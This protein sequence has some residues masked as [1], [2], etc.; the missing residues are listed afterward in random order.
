MPLCVYCDAEYPEQHAA[1]SAC[2]QSTRLDSTYPL[3]RDGLTLVDCPACGRFSVVPRQ[4]RCEGGCDLSGRWD[5]NGGPVSAQDHSR[6]HGTGTDKSQALQRGATVPSVPVPR[7]PLNQSTEP[8]P[9]AT[10]YRGQ[11]PSCP[12]CHAQVADDDRFCDRCG[13]PLAGTCATCGA[14]NR[15]TAAW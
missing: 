8:V 14:R 10:R 9:A 15:A 1:C 13:K 2:G 4:A 11:V 6:Q 5:T 3:I 7:E 12:H